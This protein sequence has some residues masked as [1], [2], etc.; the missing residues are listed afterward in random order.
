MNQR[1]MLYVNLFLIVALSL[2]TLSC[3]SSNAGGNQLADLSGVWKGSDCECEIIID[4]AS[5]TKSMTIED[6]EM[7]VSVK[8]IVDGVLSL[9]V[10]EGNGQT[11][12]WKLIQRWDDNGSTFSLALIRHG[13][14][15]A[16]SLIKKLS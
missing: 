1:N 8:G 13:K 12:V 7:A 3:G 15:E 4:L 6:Q 11:D 14:K 2:A 9:D 5:E 16:L 10:D